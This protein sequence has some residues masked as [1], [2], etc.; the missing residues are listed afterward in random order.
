[1]AVYVD[2]IILGARDEAKMTRVKEELSQSFEMKDLG[3]LHQFLGVKIAQNQPSGEIWIGQTSY[4]EKLLEKFGMNK[5]KPVSTPVNPDVK[6]STNE[7]QDSECNQKMYQGA[8]G[9][10]MYLSTKTR[11][12]IAHAMSVVARFSSNPS[13]QH[14]TAVKRICQFLKGTVTLCLLYKK[15]QTRSSGTP[16]GRCWGPKIYLRLCF[17]TCRGSHHMEEQ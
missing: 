7:A 6:L 8:V 12:D 14:W 11:P 15:T 3:P 13:N 5:C 1:M 2:D 17:L 16:G 9:S 10:L 4:T